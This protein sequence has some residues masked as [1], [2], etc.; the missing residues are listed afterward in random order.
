M[1]KQTYF[2]ALY[3]RGVLFMLF[4]ALWIAPQNFA[5]WKISL[6]YIIVVSVITVAFMVVKLL[7]SFPYQVSTHVG[8]IMVFFLPFLPP[9]IVKFLVRFSTELIFIQRKT[10]WIIYEQFKFLRKLEA[11]TFGLYLSLIYP[12][13]TK[14]IEKKFAGSIGIRLTKKR[15]PSA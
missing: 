5:K 11:P 13:K 3:T 15:I 8:P 7:H 2:L 1:Q 6:R 4:G 14:N 12:Q 9:D 10:V